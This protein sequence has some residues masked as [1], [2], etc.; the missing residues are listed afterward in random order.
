MIYDTEEFYT[1]EE[2]TVNAKKYNIYAGVYYLNLLIMITSLSKLYIDDLPTPMLFCIGMFFVVITIYIAN[3]LQNVRTGGGN[4]RSVYSDLENFAPGFI[5]KEKERKII[6]CEDFEV[7]D[8][9]KP[10]KIIDTKNSVR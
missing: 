5:F 2:S 9:E 3:G 6:E 10:K 1:I 7:V 4:L 8:E